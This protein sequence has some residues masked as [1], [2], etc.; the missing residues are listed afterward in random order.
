M[1]NDAPIAYFLTWS[2]YGTWL[3]GDERGWVEYRQG[4]Q[5]PDPVWE[6]ECAARM[7]DDSVRLTSA[8]REQVQFQVAETCSYK[9]WHLHAINCRSNHLHVVLSAPQPPKTIREQLKAW[10][11]R[12]LKQFARNHHSTANDLRSNWWT[13]RGSIRWIHDEASL[14]AAILYVRDAQDDPRRF[15]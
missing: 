1:R 13:E 3:P 9:Q 7:T 2:T 11:T 14:E 10:C 15:Q 8:Q 4:F 12:R 5:A 6:L